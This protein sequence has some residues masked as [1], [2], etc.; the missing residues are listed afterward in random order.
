VPFRAAL[1]AGADSVMIA[2]V[3][4]PQLMGDAALPATVSPAIVRG[5]L[6]ERLGFDGAVISDCLEMRAVTETVGTERGAVMALQAGID[7]LLV[8]HRYDRQLGTLRALQAAL[9]SGELPAAAVRRAAERVAQLKARALSWDDWQGGEAAVPAWVGGEAHRRLAERAYEQAVTLVRDEDGVVP[10]RLDP[11]A[12]LLV[13]YPSGAALTEANEGHVGAGAL[14]E[15]LRRRHTQVDELAVSLR[16]MDDERAEAQHRAGGA[17]VVVVVTADANRNPQQAKLARDLARLGGHTIAIAARDP[18]DLLVYPEI[19]TY[20][21]TY[22]YT[23]PALDT[24]A[25]V[26]FGE[27][28]PQGRLPVTL[29][30][31]YSR[32]HRQ[33]IGTGHHQPG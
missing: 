6:R 2:H 29:P 4:L 28:Q 18:Y 12:R 32:G 27:I 22:E 20:L 14:V 24:A 23:S 25:R 30:G 16:P 31:L 10:L 9:E 1:A 5:L 33:E 8:S 13:V 19:R 3:A 21:A 11:D 26:L 17:A 7:L 15:G